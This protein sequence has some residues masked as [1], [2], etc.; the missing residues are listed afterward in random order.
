[1]HRTACAP[2]ARCAVAVRLEETRD[3]LVINDSAERSH[4][5]ELISSRAE[6]AVFAHSWDLVPLEI[7]TEAREL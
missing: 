7:I 3:H 5:H 2:R 4:N 6:R 1:M